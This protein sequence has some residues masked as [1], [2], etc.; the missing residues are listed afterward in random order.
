MQNFK[1]LEVWR[2]AKEIAKKIYNLTD[3]FPEAERYGV[4]SQLRRASASI[5]ANIAEGCGRH[6]NK[7]FSK[8][9]YTALGSI[10]ECVHFLTLSNELRYLTDENFSI[11]NEDLDCAARKI[12]NFIRAVENNKYERRITKNEGRTK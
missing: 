11:I 8:F 10:N 2:E 6:T 12:S 1:N 7:D 4:I 9:L 3:N 5:G